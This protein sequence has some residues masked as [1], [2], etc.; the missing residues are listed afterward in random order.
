MSPGETLRCPVCRARFPNDGPCRRCGADV[1]RL[2]VL[3]ALA[4]V[5]RRR[6][7][8]AFRKGYF[9]TA[10]IYASRAQGLHATA[11]GRRLSLL[12][13]WTVRHSNPSAT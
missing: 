12:A 2:R 3:A 5:L 9:A 10:S 8:D 11:P 1:E 6:A 4:Y 13:S 7:G